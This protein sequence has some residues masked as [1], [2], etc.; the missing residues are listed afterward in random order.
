MSYMPNVQAVKWF[1][2]YC[3]DAIVKKLDNDV[4]FVIAGSHPSMEIK[5]LQSDNVIVTGY[6]E[7][8]SKT[9][10]SS[11]LS[12]APMQSGSGMQNK[13]LEAMSC[14]VPVVTTT[15]GLGTIKSEHNKHIIIQDDYAQFILAVL[16]VINYRTKYDQLALSAREFVLENHSWESHALSVENVYKEVLVDK[17][18]K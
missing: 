15:L 12:I 7:S 2:N 5:K 4:T 14:G 1:L 17:R 18:N 9:I 16:D 3:F 11:T 6:V 10:A 13:I 8:L